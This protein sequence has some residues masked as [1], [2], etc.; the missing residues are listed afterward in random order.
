MSTTAC[1]EVCQ[2]QDFE[3][4]TEMQS[5]ALPGLRLPVA[6]CRTCGF[7]TVWPRPPKGSFRSYNARWFAGEAENAGVSPHLRSRWETMWERMQDLYPAGPRRILDIGA[8]HGDAL[9]FLKSVQPEARL[10]AIELIPE[11]HPNLRQLGAE[12]HA[13]ELEQPWPDTLKGQFDL[14]IF[15]HTLEHLEDPLTALG[16]IA[17]SLAPGGMLYIAVPN[18]MQIRPGHL[19]RTDW[20]RPIHAHY[21]NQTTLTALCARVGLQPR[22]CKADREIWGLFGAFGGEDGNPISCAEQRE[23]LQ[24]RLRESAWAD[25]VA[26]LRM[27]I[28]QLMRRAGLR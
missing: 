3:K 11:F 14:V 6:I 10:A 25:R 9:A 2:G 21:F 7:V 19:M 12:A 26:I 17:A 22:R 20:F 13:V 28:G 4:L 15:R 16:N 23:Y 27:Q 1:C 8:R 18:A 24:R 5:P